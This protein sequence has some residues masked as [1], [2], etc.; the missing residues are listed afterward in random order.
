MDGTDNDVSPGIYRTGGT[1]IA[2][3]F[4]VQEMLLGE[5]STL[6]VA[7]NAVPGGVYAAMSLDTGA[8]IWS[9][10]GL[11]NLVA[12]LND[13]NVLV[14]DPALTLVDITGNNFSFNGGMS[15]WTSRY[16]GGDLWAASTANGFAVI[17]DGS[18][19]NQSQAGSESGSGSGLPPTWG[20][21][22]FVDGPFSQISPF[23]STMP[24][25]ERPPTTSDGLL[26]NYNAI[27]LNT[28]LSPQ[29]VFDL[30]LRTFVNKLPDNP[31]ARDQHPSPA[32]PKRS[33]DDELP[34]Q[35]H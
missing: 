17:S 13:G 16:L 18:A 25:V 30:Y 32:T 8:V 29:E 15:V 33:L 34:I 27:E 6:Y 11:V 10:T 24:P 7:T 5:N 1:K 2:A 22:W 35:S 12:A 19:E 31:I 28:S 4:Q 23:N 20:P 3:P 14:Q 26:S 21:L 9:K